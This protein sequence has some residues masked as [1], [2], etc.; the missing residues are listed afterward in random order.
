MSSNEL[1]S[2]RV[3]NLIVKVFL[4]LIQPLLGR[5]PLILSFPQV[6]LC[7]GQACLQLL[8]PLTPFN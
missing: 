4:Q 6:S 8:S 1:M 7:L 3:A 5:L 2:W